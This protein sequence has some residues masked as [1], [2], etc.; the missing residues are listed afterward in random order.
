MS[1]AALP[2][3]SAVRLGL[4]ENSHSGTCAEAQPR[5][6][7]KKITSPVRPAIPHCGAAEPQA[8][9]SFCAQQDSQIAHVSTGRTG[10]DGVAERDKE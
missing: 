10:R 2:L 7:S 9:C 8:D 4:T 1:V 5:R 6:I 3:S